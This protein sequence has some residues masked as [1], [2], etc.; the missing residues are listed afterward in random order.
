MCGRVEP[1]PKTSRCYAVPVNRLD[2][3]PK[4]TARHSRSNDF[5]SRPSSCLG[6]LQESVWNDAGL[7]VFSLGEPVVR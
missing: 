2:K 4:N 5:K 7:E 6:D 3:S 1:R